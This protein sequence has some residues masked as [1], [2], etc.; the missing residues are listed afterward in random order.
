[1]RCDTRASDDCIVEPTQS[2]GRKK[3]VNWACGLDHGG[4]HRSEYGKCVETANRKQRPRDA[5][6]GRLVS[7]S[8]GGGCR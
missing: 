5:K 8:A 1:M 2:A 7:I 6:A 4:S 3:A